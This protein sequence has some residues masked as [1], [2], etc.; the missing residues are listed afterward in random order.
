MLYSFITAESF[1]Y[2]YINFPTPRGIA[3]I[4]FDFKEV[5]KSLYTTVG[6]NYEITKQRNYHM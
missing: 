5:Q 6:W 3:N 2:E 4:Y 1:P